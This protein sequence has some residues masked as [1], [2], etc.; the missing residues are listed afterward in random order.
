MSKGVELAWMYLVCGLVEGRVCL[1]P[2]N[3]CVGLKC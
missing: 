1:R 3:G 2:W